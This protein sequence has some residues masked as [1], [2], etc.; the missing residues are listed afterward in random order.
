[1][2]LRR[3]LWS[4]GGGG[5]AVVCSSS[6]WGILSVDFRG[7][8][9]SG[10]IRGGFC[11]RPLSRASGVRSCDARNSDSGNNDDDGDED[12]DGDDNAA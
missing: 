3:L 11:A 6:V 10:L 2:R 12:G 4:D 5:G 8:N 7:G 1:M 9:T